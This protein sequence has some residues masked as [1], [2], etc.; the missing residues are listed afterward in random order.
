MSII[1]IVGAPSDFKV[2]LDTEVQVC[3]GLVVG[4]GATRSA[5][6]ADAIGELESVLYVLRNGG[7]FERSWAATGCDSGTVL[8]SSEDAM[9][10]YEV[11]ESTG[12]PGEWRVERVD[13]VGEGT[14]E[15]TIFSGPDA[16]ARAR[17]YA[18]WKNRQL[19][20]AHRA[21]ST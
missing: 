7:P 16:E 19:M 21:Q 12:V 8:S 5:A 15:V 2:R 3:D 11:V 13:V 1:N 20:I 4:F 9:M 18:A 10:P 17:D 14:V 6:I